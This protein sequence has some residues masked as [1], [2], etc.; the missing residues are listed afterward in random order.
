MVEG[1]DDFHRD[2]WTTCERFSCAAI[3]SGGAA[4][5]FT[6]VTSYGETCRPN[7]IQGTFEILMDSMFKWLRLH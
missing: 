5:K 7:K 1:E 6:V 2:V 4:G 3:L